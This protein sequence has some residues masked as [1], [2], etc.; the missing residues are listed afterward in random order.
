[1]VPKD[2]IISKIPLVT[3][4]YIAVHNCSKELLYLILSVKTE[5]FVLW[6]TFCP[7]KL[8]HQ[9]AK[10]QQSSLSLIIPSMLYG[11]VAYK[12]QLIGS[13]PNEFDAT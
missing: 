4:N 5:D 12:E 2:D 9:F 3:Q 1:M 6:S 11:L 10:G 13:L 7:Q 8:N